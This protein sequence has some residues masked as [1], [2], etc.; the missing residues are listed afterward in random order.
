MTF[1]VLL[2]ILLLLMG[3]LILGSAQCNRCNLSPLPISFNNAEVSLLN[4]SGIWIQETITDTLAAEA[5]A[6]SVWLG[7]STVQYYDYALNQKSLYSLGLIQ[8]TFADQC[9]PLYSPQSYVKRIDVIT[10]FDINEQLPADSS[11]ADQFYM[12]GSWQPNNE[13]LYFTPQQTLSIHQNLEVFNEPG[14][15][16]YLFLEPK[17]HAPMAQFRIIFELENGK[18]INVESPLIHIKDESGV[19]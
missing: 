16:F 12:Q 2:K 5:V 1:R 6:F 19:R 11:I 3:A 14:Y 17:V 4:N 18:I 8:K 10:L 7:D 15:N 13:D 9:E